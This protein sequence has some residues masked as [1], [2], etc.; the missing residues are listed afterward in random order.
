MNVNE[1]TRQSGKSNNENI[2]KT[3]TSTQKFVLFLLKQLVQLK[4]SE[5]FWQ[6]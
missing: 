1:Y 4:T 3:K 2:A 6:Y 5:I